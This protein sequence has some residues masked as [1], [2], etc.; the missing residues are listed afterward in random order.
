MMG[1]R[2][3]MRRPQLL[4]LPQRQQLFSQLGE[5][6]LEDGDALF[7]GFQLTGGGFGF[8]R[9]GLG[10]VGFALLTAID[11]VDDPNRLCHFVLHTAE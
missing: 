10:L 9:S 4:A 7:H 6:L 8:R 3:L 2:G 1:L 11:P 5:L